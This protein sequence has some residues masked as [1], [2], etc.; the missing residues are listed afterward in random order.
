MKKIRFF[1]PKKLKSYSDGTKKVGRKFYK[2][3]EYMKF[4]SKMYFEI[5]CV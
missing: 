4:Y 1:R 2:T 3:G 5:C